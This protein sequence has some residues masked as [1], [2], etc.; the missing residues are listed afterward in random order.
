VN[1]FQKAWSLLESRQRVA[2]AGLAVLMTIA[3]I[4]EMVGVGLIVPALTM[5]AG[6]AGKSSPSMYRIRAIFGDPS[7]A[8]LIV[9]GLCLLLALYATKT[10]FSLF[11]VWRQVRF[12][13][14]V[15]TSLARRLFRNYLMQPWAFH[16]QRNSAAMVSAVVSEVG[17]YAN[18]VNAMLAFATESLVVSG[19]VALLIYFEP[20]GA[21]GVATLLGLATWAFLRFFQHRVISWGRRR[22][23]HD[24]ERT[25][26]VQQGL[27]GAKEVKLAG[28][29]REFIEQFSKE[30]AGGAA[31]QS[32]LTAAQYLP[33]LWYELMAVAGLALLA[34]VMAAQGIPASA[35]VAKL[36]LFAVAAFRILPSLNRMMLTWQ[37]V[38]FSEAVVDSLLAECRLPASEPPLDA[39][40]RL[41]FAS[42]IA[43]DNI[44]YRYPNAA[45]AALD[46]ISLTIPIGTALGIIGSSGAGKSTLVDL[47]L[48]LLQP[49]SGA[50]LV[51]GVDIQ[52]SL[53]RWQRCIG[54]VP[55]SIYLLDDT[56]SRNIAFG[57]PDADIDPAAVQRALR[58][59]Q[60]S[61]FVDTLPNKE[62]TYVGER[63][64]RLS[65]GQRQRIGIA[66]ALYH[67][68]PILVLDE[69][70]SALDTATEQE[71]MAAVNGLHGAKTL[72]IIAHRLSTLRGCDVLIRLEAGKVVHQGEFAE[73]ADSA[74]SQ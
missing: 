69:A 45:Q 63:G 49:D 61:E 13:V 56:I 15:Q 53:R 6:G 38:R 46:Q 57:I 5:L 54:Y 74:S 1:T 72:V 23:E 67:D 26:H 12:V 2:A 19:M 43:I 30:A 22:R 4:L 17:A 7:N 47:L 73:L 10:V 51:D 28:R 50:V 66:R 40:E 65:G 42:E 60:L 41:P 48:G 11:L 71:V 32:R 37:T 55:Q 68:P 3:M 52:D 39:P 59:A 58:A 70:T 35:M 24:I 64:V 62:Q 27:A 34:G 8:Q 16:L 31:M 25:K 20:V 21:L 44:T 29:E 18:A 33:R 9:I 14:D 36:G